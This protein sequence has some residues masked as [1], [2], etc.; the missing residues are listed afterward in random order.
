MKAIINVNKNS[1]YA[2]LNGKTFWVKEVLSNLV[3]IDIDGCTIDFHHTEVLIVELAAEMQSAFDACNWG[4][5]DSATRYNNLKAYCKANGFITN[6][7]Y[8][9]AQ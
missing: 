2:H 3:A 5:G 8:T 6:E 9:P 1:A 7:T 4:G